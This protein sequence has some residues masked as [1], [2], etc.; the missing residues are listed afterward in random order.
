MPLQN[1]TISE[2]IEALIDSDA[3]RL[4]CLIQTYCRLKIFERFS[5]SEWTYLLGKKAILVQYFDV[6]ESFTLSE[7]K[8]L[9]KR[10]PNLWRVNRR[11]LLARR[12][13]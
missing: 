9:L 3:T 12:S 1:K 5:A 10:Q 7:C 8:E 11:E 6:W 4:S 2:L 13:N